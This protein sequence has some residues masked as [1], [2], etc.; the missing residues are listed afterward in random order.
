MKATKRILLTVLTALSHF[1]FADSAQLKM[2]GD[3]MIHPK[4]IASFFSLATKKI[5]AS[6]AWDWPSLTFDKPY[7]T[8]WSAV[9]ARGPFAVR[10]NTANLAKQ[11]VG[12]ELDWNDPAVYVGRFEIHDTLIRDVGGARLIIHLDG[13]CNGMM[14]RVPT[15]AWKVRGSLKWG[16]TNQGLQVAWNDFQ[17]VNNSGAATSVDLGQCDGP[18]GLNEALKDAI[19]QVSQDHAWM[20]DVLRDGVLNW[21]EGSLGD[22]QTELM[23]T[24]EVQMR[25][26][27]MLTW[28]PSNMMDAGNGLMRI[29]GQMVVSKEAKVASSETLDR[30][31]SESILNE[32]TESGFVLPRETLPKMMEFLQRHGELGYRASSNQIDSFKSLMGSRFLQF[33]VWPDLMKFAKTT[34]FY[35]DVSTEKAP[36]LTNGRSLASG[37]AYDVSAPLLV[38]QWAPTDKKYL[39]YVDFRAPMQGSLSAQIKGDELQVLLAPAKM[40]VT[41]AFRPEFQSFRSVTTRIANSMLGSKVQEYLNSKPLTLTVPAWKLGDGLALGMKDVK[42]YDQSFR[43]PLEFKPSAK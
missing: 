7:K 28:V 12:F 9:Q 33:F 24:R 4:Q 35:F 13:A 15:G 8:S 27:L 2:N 10:F 5:D 36:V 26:G 42:L 31:F 40:N 34:E 3:L 11:E 29:M 21:I 43:I 22:L 38:K 17:F 14:I 32:V 20:Q 37:V 41:S 1:A 19:M 39:P 25:P 30:G 16:W 6:S 18:T 23:K